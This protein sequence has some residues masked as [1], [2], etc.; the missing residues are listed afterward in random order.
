MTSASC[1]AGHRRP[2]D[3]ACCPLIGNLK[4]GGRGIIREPRLKALSAGE[5]PLY[6]RLILYICVLCVNI[7]YKFRIEWAFRHV[8]RV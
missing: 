4:T 5:T 8:D 6:N 7:A 3:S 2:I 1:W